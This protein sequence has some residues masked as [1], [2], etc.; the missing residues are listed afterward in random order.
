MR[1]LEE[2]KDPEKDAP[3]LDMDLVRRKD[4]LF[5]IAESVDDCVI[6]VVSVKEELGLYEDSKEA[7]SDDFVLS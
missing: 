5:S 7:C 2:R 6:V 3:R 4:P 1:V